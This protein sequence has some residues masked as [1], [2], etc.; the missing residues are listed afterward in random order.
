MELAV[1]AEALVSACALT[2]R[3]TCV[4]EN[5]DGTLTARFGYTSALQHLGAVVHR[6]PAN[7]LIPEL[8]PS[9]DHQIFAPIGSDDAFEVT[10]TD[11]VRWILGSRRAVANRES[12]RCP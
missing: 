4:R 6:G 8:E 11:E 7:R 12:P 3:V 10:F 1:D 9:R 2:P 5:A